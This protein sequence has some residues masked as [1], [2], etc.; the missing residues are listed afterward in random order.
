MADAVWEEKAFLRLLFP[1]IQAFQIFGR[2][3]A[4][5]LFEGAA[6]GG[7][8]RKAG[9]FARFLD[10]RALAEQLARAVD[11]QTLAIRLKRFARFLP[12]DAGEVVFAHLEVV[13][14]HGQAQRRI[15]DALF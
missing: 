10:A 13:R 15:G 9:A 8:G 11:A 5:D 2:R 3:D 12:H 14:E 1:F 6:K 7:G 4:H